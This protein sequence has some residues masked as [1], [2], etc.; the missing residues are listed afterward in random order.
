[1]HRIQYGRLA[2]MTAVSFIAMFILM[3]AMV[4]RFASGYPNVNQ[5]YMAGLMAAPMVIIELFVMRAMYPD[6]KM[7]MIYG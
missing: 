4:D 7:N 5:F 1:M 2:L 6:T 3:Y